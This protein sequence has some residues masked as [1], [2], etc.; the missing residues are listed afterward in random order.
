MSILLVLIL[1]FGFVLGGF[2]GS[3]SSSSGTSELK[4]IVKCSKRMPAE[5]QRGQERRRCGPPPAK[6]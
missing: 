6:P 5:S 2:G 1:L 3:S 4:P